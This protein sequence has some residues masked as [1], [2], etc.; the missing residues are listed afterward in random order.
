MDPQQRLMLEVARECLEDAGVAEWRAKNI[1]CYM[2][3]LFE[4]WC[5]MFAKGN[6][7]LGQISSNGLWRFCLVKSSLLRN[8]F[9]RSKVAHHMHSALFKS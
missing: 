6:A 3:S 7:Q 9:A 8:G 4:D 1:G 2:G 5:E